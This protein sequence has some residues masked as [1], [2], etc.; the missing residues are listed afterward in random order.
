MQEA[1]WSGDRRRARP[2]HSDNQVTVAF[3]SR[4]KKGNLVRASLAT[5]FH[6]KYLLYLKSLARLVLARFFDEHLQAI[7]HI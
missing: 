6:L 3:A 5:T 7:I 2:E 4:V 1:R